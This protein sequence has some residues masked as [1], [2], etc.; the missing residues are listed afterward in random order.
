[1]EVEA[2]G[3]WRR[4]VF[5]RQRGLLVARE[6]EALDAEKR[7]S[8]HRDH[9]ERLHKR[10]MKHLVSAFF[11]DHVTGEYW[12]YC[13]W[14][15]A[16]RVF[17][18]VMGTMSTQAML[19][20]IG[21]GSSRAVPAAAALNWVLKDGLG[22]M[23][24]LAVTA[25]FGRAF[26]SDL[27]RF[28][29]VASV[30]MAACETLEMLTPFFPRSFLLLASASSCGKA[31]ALSAALAVQPAIHK[32]FATVDNM[33]EVTAKSQ[34]QH[35]VVDNVGLAIAVLITKMLYPRQRQAPPTRIL[36]GP[37]VL[38]PFLTACEL[39]CTHHELRA[40]RLTSLNRERAELAA[41][42]WASSRTVPSPREV[43]CREGLF[44]P[45]EMLHPECAPPARIRPLSSMAQTPEDL[46]GLLQAR[47]PGTKHVLR[48]VPRKGLVPKGGE[49]DVAIAL[50][51][52]ASA[53][54]V[55]CA[56]LQAAYLRRE[57]PGKGALPEAAMRAAEARAG[58]RAAS[59]VGP[60]IR[61]LQSQGWETHRVLLSSH[62][63]AR[64]ALS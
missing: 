23:G 26:D 6:Q 52:G 11:P 24:K 42:A 38:F 28:R 8:T 25:A 49:C 36:S 3:H 44:W 31:V 45:S 9:A 32:S 34:A 30:V 22:K 62:E 20:A 58:A 1:M 29:F 4:V 57:M 16:H 47:V 51:E 61:A 13:K 56:L 41:A 55:L 7:G 63:R 27:K 35:V 48:A 5:D 2:G 37:I 10:V 19:T 53:R 46:A 50:Q 64:F 14:R 21:V 33:A 39:F 60:M 59:E 18:A 12:E 17:S 43:S 54:D 40:V 15:A